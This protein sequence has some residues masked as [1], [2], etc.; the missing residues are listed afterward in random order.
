MF[1]TVLKYNSSVHIFHKSNSIQ[2]K[3]KRFCIH[4]LGSL[5]TTT[6]LGVQYTALNVFKQCTYRP[7]A[8]SL[9]TK[10]RR[11]GLSESI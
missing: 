7:T 11:G 6:H 10:L 9:D 4:I 2:Y 3:L 5:P 8:L 1:S